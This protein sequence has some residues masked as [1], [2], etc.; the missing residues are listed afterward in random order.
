MSLERTAV[1]LIELE[2]AWV[3]ILGRYTWLCTE[4]LT[5]LA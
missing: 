2:V 3:L 1:D 5:L 4:L